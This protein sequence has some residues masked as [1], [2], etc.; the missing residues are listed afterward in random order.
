MLPVFFVT[1]P[2]MTAILVAASALCSAMAG[3]CV[4]A[5]TIDLG[6]KHV[7]PVFG[8]MNMLGNFGAALFAGVAPWLGGWT[9]V[10]T[11]VMVLNF[12]CVIAW[13]SAADRPP[14]GSAAPLPS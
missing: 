2:E 12:L 8:V 3:P 9:N 1:N 10:L 11:F 5:F 7:A 4:F 14:I 13:L 6:G